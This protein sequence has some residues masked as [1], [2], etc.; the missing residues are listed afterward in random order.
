MSEEY[1]RTIAF[2]ALVVMQWADAFNARSLWQSIF[3]RIK[4]MNKSFYVGLTIA[5]S[6]HILAMFGPMQNPLSIENVQL[7]HLLITSLI[8][9]VPII[10][11]GELHKLIIQRIDPDFR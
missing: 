7:N 10:I 5:V 2:N 9:I 1:A 6:M 4:T 3:I 8:A 11:A